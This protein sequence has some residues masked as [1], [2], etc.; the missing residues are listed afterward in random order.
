MPMQCMRIILKDFRGSK[1]RRIMADSVARN[2]MRDE[3]PTFISCTVTHS[4]YVI[5][6]SPMHS[7]AGIV[8]GNNC[9]WLLLAG[10]HS[11]EC[12]GEFNS[13]VR[14]ALIR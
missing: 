9:L 13:A 3:G 12:L 7:L 10:K 2:Y 6:R 1:N 8:F 11:Y 5:T 4:I 14:Q